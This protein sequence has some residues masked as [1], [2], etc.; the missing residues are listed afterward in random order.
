MVELQFM[1]QQSGGLSEAKLQEL[2]D[3]LKLDRQT[4]DEGLQEGK[5]RQKVLSDK[6]RI[7]QFGINGAPKLLLNGR[8]VGSKGQTITESCISK[9]IEQELGQVNGNPGK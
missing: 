6:K 1:S 9:L 2:A 7:N 4:F 3:S 5:Y 8:L